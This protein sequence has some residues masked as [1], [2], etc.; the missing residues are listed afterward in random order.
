MK[1]RK[2]D[3]EVPKNFP[4]LAEDLRI[5]TEGLFSFLDSTVDALVLSL[6]HI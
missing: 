5:S 6:I 4:F 3:F 1:L 2:K